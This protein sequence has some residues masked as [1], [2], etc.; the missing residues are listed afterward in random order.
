MK[1]PS[2]FRF[3][4]RLMNSL[5]ARAESRNKSLTEHVQTVLEASL[6]N[7]DFEKK[8]YFE[9]MDNPGKSISDIY[10]KL[11]STINTQTTRLSLA[12]LKSLY[13]T[14]IRPIS[15]TA[16]LLAMITSM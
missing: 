6:D 4:E 5:K 7:E 2:S 15:F 9:L 10:I 1:V 11:F 14:A 13:T 16:M 8:H 3:P 12:E